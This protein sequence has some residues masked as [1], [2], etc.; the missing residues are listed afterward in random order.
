MKS[1]DI[2]FPSKHNEN[3]RLRIYYDLP[4]LEYAVVIYLNIDPS[5][6]V[7]VRIHSACLTGDI[8]N[9]LKCDCHD[10][11]NTS[12]EYI[13][14]NSGIIIYLPQEGRGIGLVNKIKAYKLQSM[15]LDTF[16]ANSRLNLPIDNRDY[17]IC[18][19]ILHDFHI[20]KVE[21]ITNNPKKF[22]TLHD[23]KL[24]SFIQYKRLDIEPN[25][26]SSRYLKDKNLFFSNLR[27]GL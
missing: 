7:P 9:S 23:S 8:F 21:L 1:E 24:I 19:A 14:N 26:Y 17:S 27:R 15:G 10:Q 4:K 18:P 25:K 11:L 13:S 5:N 6:I 3:F 2:A 16:E 20:N 22:K 12:L